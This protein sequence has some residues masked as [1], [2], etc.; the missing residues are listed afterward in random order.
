MSVLVIQLSYSSI[1][2][3][4]KW[5]FSYLHLNFIHLILEKY[6]EIFR[7]VEFLLTMCKLAG[8]KTNVISYTGKCGSFY[9][10][11]GAFSVSATFTVFTRF[12]L[13]PDFYPI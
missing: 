1:S 6:I 5:Q 8:V 4:G 11:L 3:Y 2:F 13:G 12:N 7:F 9:K 10:N